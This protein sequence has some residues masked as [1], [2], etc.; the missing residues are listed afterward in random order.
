MTKIVAIAG[1]FFWFSISTAYADLVT[2][3]WSGAINSSPA[4]ISFNNGD[5][6]S[7]AFVFDST[8]PVGAISGTEV[9]YATNHSTMFS[10]NGLNVFGSGGT[11]GNDLYQ[12]CVPPVVCIGLHD[13]NIESN[14]FSGD[15]LG[16]LAVDHFAFTM[17]WLSF[18]SPISPNELPSQIAIPP[19]YM[20]ADIFLQG[21]TES[22]SLDIEDVTFSRVSSVPSPATAW[23]L[24]AALVVLRL[25]VRMGT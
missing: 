19:N 11:I 22:I 5:S 8:S 3:D 23:L 18:T 12:A 4:P 2:I 15:L 13:L 24:G 10:I 14:N 25:T 21:I 6:I 17:G 9:V 16:G 1:L 7:G 20:E